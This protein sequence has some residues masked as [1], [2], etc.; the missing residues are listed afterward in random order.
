MPLGEILYEVLSKDYYECV[1]NV[2]QYFL[3]LEN[4]TSST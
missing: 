2:S 3:D 1:L 4:S